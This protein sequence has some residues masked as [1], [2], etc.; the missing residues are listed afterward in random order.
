MERQPRKDSVGRLAELLTG[1]SD[2]PPIR[3]P[4]NSRNKKRIP[5]HRG[6][7]DKR[8]FLNVSLVAFK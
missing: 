3:P 5:Q 6:H 8:L 4:Q 2:N 7:D 1:D